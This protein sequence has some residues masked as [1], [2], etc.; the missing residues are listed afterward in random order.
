MMQEQ[1]KSVH[2]MVVTFATRVR[3][4]M[5]TYFITVPGRRA[6]VVPIES[7]LPKHS[8]EPSLLTQKT[9]TIVTIRRAFVDQTVHTFQ[10]QDE[11]MA[12]GCRDHND[13]VTTAAEAMVRRR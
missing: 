3:K 7:T 5:E 6:A 13:V 2:S 9:T 8:I 11:I 12:T 10:S 1:K 4:I